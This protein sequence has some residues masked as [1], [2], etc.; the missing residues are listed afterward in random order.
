M[1]FIVLG[2]QKFQLN[3]LL[4]IMDN[5]V[6]K[7]IVK[8]PVFAQRGNSDYIPENY[9]SVEF[10]EKPEFDRMIAKADIIITHSGVGSIIAALKAK[11]PVIVFPRRKKYREHVDDHQLDIARAFA[12][13]DYVLCCNQEEELADCIR[14]SREKNFAEYVSERERAVEMIQNFLA[15]QW[16]GEEEKHNGK[17]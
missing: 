7:G 16:K 6:A 2:T 1:I 13:K 9:E 10:L 8:E 5:Y 4:K 11:K 15:G 14:K 12:K 17:G 3:R